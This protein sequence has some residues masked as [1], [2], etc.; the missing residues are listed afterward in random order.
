[1]YLGIFSTPWTILRQCGSLGLALTREVDRLRQSSRC[2][3]PLLVWVGVSSSLPVSVYR[4]HCS[5]FDI[6]EISAWLTRTK[7]SMFVHSDENERVCWGPV[8][9]T[10][11]YN[12]G[13]VAPTYP[14]TCL[15]DTGRHTPNNPR[16]ECSISNAKF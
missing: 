10:E 14:R 1:M 12:N 2:S 8:T 7:M 9:N 4:L 16:T 11:R 6:V 5:C 3:H 15:C 13:D